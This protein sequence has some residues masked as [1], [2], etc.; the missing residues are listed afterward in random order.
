MKLFSFGK[1]KRLVSNRQFRA[2]LANGKRFSDDLL[3]LYM[4]AN[5]C[6]YPRVGISLGKSFGNAVARNRLKRRLREVF[7]RSQGRIPPDFDY[8]LM[9]SRQWS[10]KV[11]GTKMPKK[12]LIQPSFE[13]VEASFSALV[14]VAAGK[15][16]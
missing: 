1:N 8:L 7:R 13:Q 6:G 4:A 3:T 14:A 15:M 5:D 12:S 2:V 16:Q 10:N 11:D 9:I